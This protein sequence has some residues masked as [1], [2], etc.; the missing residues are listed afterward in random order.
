MVLAVLCHPVHGCDFT[1]RN[2]LIGAMLCGV[3]ADF[4]LT[5]GLDGLQPGRL[6]PLA[7]AAM[8]LVAMLSLLLADEVV[9]FWGLVSALLAVITPWWAPR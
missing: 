7:A 3:P 6:L 2:L 9:R 5:L 1:S 8:V 4:L